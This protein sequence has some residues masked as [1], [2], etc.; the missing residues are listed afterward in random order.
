M[1]TMNITVGSIEVKMVTTKYG[2]KPTYLITGTDGMRYNCG[3]KNPRVVEGETFSANCEEG[4]Y[5][6]EVDVSSVKKGSTVSVAT[7]TAAPTTTAAK[8]P[9][10][11]YGP[12]V[13][14]FPIP[15]LHGDRAII[16]QNALTNARELYAASAGGKP[17]ALDADLSAS[18]IIELAR[19]FEAYSCGD[20]DLEAAVA[21]MKEEA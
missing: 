3:F 19:K 1:T 17:F 21:A 8:E 9:T 13:K 6:F 20:L 16:R 5:G 12:P 7:P 18:L 2:A 14:P 15:P 4:K 11:S 10:R